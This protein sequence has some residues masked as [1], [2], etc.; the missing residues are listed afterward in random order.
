MAKEA[1]RKMRRVRLPWLT[2]VYAAKEDEWEAALAAKHGEE[3]GGE[4]KKAVL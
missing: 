4:E 3:G 2:D 1:E